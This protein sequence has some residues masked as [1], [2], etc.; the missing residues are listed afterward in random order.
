MLEDFD[1]TRSV[2]DERPGFVSASLMSCHSWRLFKLESNLP[3]HTFWLHS[4]YRTKT[5]TYVFED[6]SS[7]SLF[8]IS[9]CGWSATLEFLKIA[10]SNFKPDS[11]AEDT[12]RSSEAWISSHITDSVGLIVVRLRNS[13]GC[14]SVQPQP[15]KTYTT[16]SKQII[17][18]EAIIRQESFSVDSL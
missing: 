10:T 9:T 4:S 12:C 13:F 18:K 16:V 14:L 1:A 15:T 2:S 6:V 3:K 11:R 7:K 5:I 17:D 8:H